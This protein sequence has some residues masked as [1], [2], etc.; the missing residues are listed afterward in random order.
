[1]SACLLTLIATPAL[2]ERLIDWLLERGQDGFTT[3]PCHG[4]GTGHDGLSAA[5]QVAGR[6]RQVAFWLQVSSDT[7]TELV[8]E[9]T[10]EFA[11]AQLHYWIVPVAA[12][13]PLGAA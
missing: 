8:R 1:M 3:L 2:E 6:K 10:A 12:G 9:L 11:D 13:G 7:A 4:H 5:E